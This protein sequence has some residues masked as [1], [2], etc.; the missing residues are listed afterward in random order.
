MKKSAGILVYRSSNNIT[1]VFLVHPGGPFWKGKDIGAWSI[2]KGEFDEGEVPLDAAKREFKEET[3]V[4]IDGKFIALA[5]I[6]QKGGKIV[7]AWMVESDLNIS[8]I[9]S[10]TFEIEWPYKS[11]IKK[12]FPEIDKAAWF[13]IPEAMIKINNAQV[14]LI[15]EL[16][17]KLLT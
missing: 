14:A 12:S 3:G 17:E 1:E 6:K 13:T 15:E 5:P 7:F 11:G 10:N 8:N 4:L 9:V 16:K 2:P